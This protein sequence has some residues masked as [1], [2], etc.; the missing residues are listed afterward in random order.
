[1]ADQNRRLWPYNYGSDNP[2]RFVDPDG[3]S[4]ETFSDAGHIQGLLDWA[5]MASHSE[6]EDEK[7]ENLNPIY[8][9]EGNLL[10]PDDQ[11][12]Q[13]MALV[14]S[15]KGFKHGMSH[16]D[17]LRKNLGLA[18][19][20]DRKAVDNLLASYESLP[21]R[22]DWDGH[23]TLSEANEWYRA[24]G[25]KPL[26]VALNKIDLSYIYSLGEKY[27]G[28][29]K[30]F[31]LLFTSGPFDDGLV[32]GNITLKRY[33]HNRVRAFADRYDFDMHNPW[34]PLNWGRNFETVIGRKVAGKGTPFEINIYGSAI[35]M[36]LFPWT[37]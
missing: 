19:L 35:L 4:R 27:V 13:G 37:K 7:G 28:Q 32:Y 22:P 36:P 6:K 3:M 11:G 10:G 26:F 5:E 33:P 12:L 29:V 20:K 17:A 24:G 23:L 31:N 34:N 15:K 25:G 21:S 14:M 8:D 30:A 2:V 1:M 9:Q 16:A 18:G